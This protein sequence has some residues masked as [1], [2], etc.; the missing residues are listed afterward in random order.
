MFKRYVVTFLLVVVSAGV[1]IG[2]AAVLPESGELSET[3]A[4]AQPV[5]IPQN[6]DPMLV[7]PES[8]SAGNQVTLYL[9]VTNNGG[10]N[11][12]NFKTV[13]KCLSYCGLHIRIKGAGQSNF[14]HGI[15]NSSLNVQS[16]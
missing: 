10:G 4:V 5:N 14:F 15:C 9:T 13:G 3:E 1:L 8:T 6:S 2:C 7:V 11:L 16:G 12:N